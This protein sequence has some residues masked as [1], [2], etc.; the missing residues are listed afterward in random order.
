MISANSDH[1]AIDALLSTPAFI[2]TRLDL[3]NWGPFGGRHQAAI[4]I[5]G[6]AI[7]GQTGSGKTTLIDALMTLIAAQPRYNL[8]STGGHESDRDLVSYVRGVSG[9]GREGDTDHISRPG[10]TVSAIAAT[11]GNGSDTLTIAGIFSLEGSG[12]SATELDRIWMIERGA[13]FGLDELLELHNAGGKR[14]LRQHERAS[15]GSLKVYDSKKAY[16]LELRR[17]FEVG[18]NAFTLLNR[19]AGLKQLNSIDDLFRDLVLDDRSAFP[20]ALEVASEFD[21]LAEIRE[22]L[23]TARKQR[24]SLVPI[25]KGWA[26]RAERLEQRDLQVRLV[27]LLPIAVATREHQLWVDREREL[28]QEKAGCERRIEDHT[29]RTKELESAAQRLRDIYLRDGGSGIEELEGKLEAERKHLETVRRHANDYVLFAKKLQFSQALTLETFRQNEASAQA[30][31]ASTAVAIEEAERLAYAKGAA[32]AGTEQT[33]TE[34]QAALANAKSHPGS[35][36]PSLYQ[37]FRRDLAGQLNLHDED[38]PFVAEL[39]EVQKSQSAWRGAIERAMGGHRLRIMVPASHMKLALAWVNG[40][41]NRLHVRLVDVMAPDRAVEF[42]IDGFTRKLNFKDHPYREAVRGLLAQIDRHCVASPEVL[43]HTPH[44][45][46]AQGLMS[47]KS[48]FFEKQDKTP[49]SQGWLTG[50]D[51]KDLL[52]ELERQCDETARELA[53]LTAKFEAARAQVTE[54]QVRRTMLDRVLS[55]D[56]ADIDVRQAERNVADSTRRLSA[57]TDPSSD[58]ARAKQAWEEVR[59]ELEKISQARDESLIQQTKLQEQYD[60]AVNGRERAFATIGEGLNAI[61]MALVEQHFDFVGVQTVDTLMRQQAQIDVRLRARLEEL[62]ARINDHERQLVRGMGAARA[63]D[64]GALAEVGTEVEDVPQYLER[65]RVLRDEALPEKLDRFLG[66]LNQSSDEGVTQLLRSI[67]NEVETIVE[68]IEDLNATMR[69]V[70]FQPGRYLQ[71]EPRRVVHESLRTLEQAQRTLRAATL[72]D[73]QGESQFNALAEVVRLMRDA[74]ERRTTVGAKAL[75]DPRYRLQFAVSVIE[76]S[77]GA[78]C[79]T[80]KGSQG[81]SGGEKEIIASY[82]LTASLSYALCPDGKDR[83]LFGTIVLDEAFSKSSQ[84]V[85][86]RIISALREFGLHPL[87]VTPNKEMRLLRAHTRSAILIHRKGLQ[88]TMTSLSWE[89]LDSI[90]RARQMTGR[91]EITE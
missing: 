53:E 29:R 36:I 86:G 65:L 62:A 85:A 23:E 3:F 44:G 63:V 41:D 27:S 87:F 81:G 77:S 71:L 1:R 13:E 16:I 60:T 19:A 70:D 59:A 64:T 34:Q 91:D 10:K 33:L 84:A 50:F 45:M 74:S 32:L 40:R 39:V 22:E 4:D 79:E 46:T 89:E 61:E 54:V 38:L 6:T 9:A 68:R 21:N 83:P 25:E 90:A 18:E 17:I 15:S 28:G 48:G 51:N 12:S 2:L 57:L 52:A 80:R 43:K 42:L 78:V 82:I 37:Q 75:L 31:L 47:G 58:T 35:N 55:I 49:L 24:D 14:A 66:Y 73:D 8:A 69:R 20:R 56:F 5:E 67:D 88:A 11:F 72:Q 30:L 7:I 76:R 26:Q